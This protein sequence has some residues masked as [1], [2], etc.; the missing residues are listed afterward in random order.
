MTEQSCDLTN[1]Y[2]CTLSVV[3]KQGGAT[4]TGWV[5]QSYTSRPRK[6]RRRHRNSYQ[7]GDRLAR[8]GRRQPNL[9]QGF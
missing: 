4:P 5:D 9:Q 1:A 2:A 7:R 8:D 6:L 3:L